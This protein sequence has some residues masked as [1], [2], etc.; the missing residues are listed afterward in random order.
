MADSQFVTPTKTARGLGASKTGTSHHIRQRV[1]ALALIVLMPWF[2]FSIMKA[3]LTGYDAAIAWVGSPLNAILLV[4]TA[5]AAF[6]HMRLGMQAVVEDY[7]GKP[8][9][10]AALLILNTF[11]SAG[12]FVAVVMSV[13]RIWTGS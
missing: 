5:G 4:L 3:T 10:R 9:T 6:Y 1:S 13:I 7:I 2:L 12:L 11:F 8:G